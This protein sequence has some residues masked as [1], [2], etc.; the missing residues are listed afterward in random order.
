MGCKNISPYRGICG[1]FLSFFKWIPVFVISGIVAWS[2]YAYVVHLCILT[3]ESDVEKVLLLIPYHILATLFLASYWRTVWTR[4]GDIPKRFRLTADELDNVE[5]SENDETQKRLLE[6]I[7]IDKDL[8]VA[9]RTIQGA[10]RY[11]EKCATVKPDRAHHCSVCGT[12]VLKMDHHCPWVNN[13]VAFNNYKFFV[14]F[15]LYGLVYCLFV[16]LSTLKYFIRFWTRSMDGQ[17]GHGKFHILFLFFV[18]AMFC[19]SLCSLLG[20]HIH[21]VLNNRT[22]LEAFRAPV[23]R[24]GPDKEGFSLGKR[25]NIAEVFGDDWWRVPLPVFSSFGDGLTYPQRFPEDAEVGYGVGSTTGNGTTRQAAH[26]QD[27]DPGVT[28]VVQA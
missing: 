16:A 27:P 22:T 2:Y 21:L 26:T 14:L 5:G 13:C 8:P 3:I 20:Y 24:R 28:L 18:S 4:P 7:I 23:F 17:V 19:I 11:C 1:F 10:V 25:G 6:Q 15:L 9:M 12:C